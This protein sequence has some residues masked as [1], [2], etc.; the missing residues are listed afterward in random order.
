MIKSFLVLLAIVAVASAGDY[1]MKIASQKPSGLSSPQL[2]VG[3]LLYGLTGFGWFYLMRFHSLTAIG[4][5]FSAVTIVALTVLGVVLFK[6]PFGARQVL[7]V[8][9][10]IASVIVIGT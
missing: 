1:L 6:E 8:L 10:A 7:G 9:L 4:V 5:I 2:Y 3:V